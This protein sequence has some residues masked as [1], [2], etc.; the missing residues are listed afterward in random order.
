M[1][2]FRAS[3]GRPISRTELYLRLNDRLPD[4]TGDLLLLWAG[5]RA[6][7]KPVQHVI[8]EQAFLD[9]DYRVGPDVLIPRP[10]T[11]ILVT[12][13][14]EELKR[15]PEAPRLGLEIGTGSGVISIELLSAFPGLEMV[16]SELTPEA[17]ARAGANARTILG[18]SQASRLRI[19]RSTEP[20]QVFEP[21]D[22]GGTLLADFLIS[23]PPYLTRE[24]SVE[25]EVL[26]FEPHTALFAPPS[27]PLYFYRAMAKEGATRLRPAAWAFLELAHERADEALALFVESGWKNATLVDDLTGRHRVLIATSPRTR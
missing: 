4:E 11:E 14:I 25:T 27:D 1:A 2:A 22:A 15:L 26:N 17:I 8:G 23:N 5:K 16:A 3:A 21:F 12:R 20:T 18:D 7:G 19:L 6:E 24:D 10:E 9:H 13:A